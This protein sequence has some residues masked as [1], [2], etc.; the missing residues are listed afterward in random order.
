MRVAYVAC[1]HGARAALEPLMPDVPGAELVGLLRADEVYWQSMLQ[2]VGLL[3]CGTS[4]SEAGRCV[5]QTARAVACRQSIPQIVVEDFPGNF[6]A[7]VGPPP[8]VLV[9]ELEA[10][11]FL[12]KRTRLL[13]CPGLRYDAFR[14]RV[15]ELRRGSEVFDATT[16]LWAGQPETDACIRTLKALMPALKALKVRLLF[17]A[18]PRDA[19]YSL[20]AYGSLLTGADD[21]TQLPLEEIF[22]R[23][24][25]MAITQFSSVAV[26]AGFWGVPALNILLPGAGLPLLQRKGYSQLPWC[27]SGAALSTNEP[28]D[29]PVMLRAGVHDADTR[30]ALL[31]AFD[32]HFNVHEQCAPGVVNFLYNQRLL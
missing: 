19:G 1:D 5:E 32:R 21:V 8:S 13:R 11:A 24:P 26:E 12:D 15:R 10:V 18:H 23:R 22:R 27:V 16:V 3:V 17:R 30:E 6:C 20:G 28:Q 9:T 4:D 31:A 7:T 25:A 29:I 2:G 14:S